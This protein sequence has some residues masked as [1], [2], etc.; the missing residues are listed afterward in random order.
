[1]KILW[2]IDNKFR[3]LYGLYDL[4]KKLSENGIKLYLIYIPIWKTAIDLV[5]PHIIVVP[6]LYKNSCEPI[7]KYAKK[8]KID[9]FM[10]SSEGMYYSDNVQ[11]IKYPLTIIK[12]IN[13]ILVWGKDDAKY[14]IKKGFKHK[15]VETGTL[16]FDKKNYLK[17]NFNNKK[18]SIIG[19]P[20]HLRIISGFGKSK[21]MIPFLIRK[22]ILEKDYEKFGLYK[23]EYEYI[24][25]LTEVIKTI[26]KNKKV[27]FKISP[28]EDP[29]IY[30]NTFPE[31]N[32]FEGNDVRKFLKNVDVILNVYSSISVDA[33]KYNV[34]V[35]SINRLIN[36]DTAVIKG[37]NYGPNAKHGSVSL[38]IQSNNIIELNNLLKKNKKYLI[39]LCKK[40]NFFEKADKLAV[41]CDTL[42][43]MTN[44]FINHKTKISY[45]PYNYFLYLKYLLVEIR[46]S[47]FRRPR[48]AN[49]KQWKIS[50]KN[51]LKEFRLG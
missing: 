2:V 34:P 14:L 38:G 44:L 20:T 35:I 19:I 12:K 1:M 25:L 17:K 16:K 3:E 21:L 11:K 7:V 5:N 6:N 51:L 33:L 50:D 37:K 43:L 31:Q 49:F 18:I 24:R 15:I 10:H 27:L 47:F 41:S 45:R 32:I 40:K 8:K 13:K 4:K 22:I 46:Q 26:N 39:D 29:K 28:F 36:W 9:I 48:A 30:R 42:Q 23:F